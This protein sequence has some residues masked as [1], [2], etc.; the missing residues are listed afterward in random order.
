MT[1]F[2]IQEGIYSNQVLSSAQYHGDK[3]SISR[4][5]LMEFDKSPHRFRALFLDENAPIKPRTPAMIFGEA[6]HTYLLEPELF[7]KQFAITP[8]PVL[9]KDVG[10]EAYEAYKEELWQLKSTDKQLLTLDEIDA[11]NAM[12]EA[13]DRNPHA[14]DLIQ[15]A[16]YEQSFFWQHNV[17]GLMV[18]SRPDILHH[19]MYVDIKTIADA[20]PRSFQNSMV[21][22]GY[23]IQG[24]MLR[25]AIRYFEGRD[26]SN[27]INICVEKT[28]PFSI[29]IYIIDEAA[30]DFG[31]Q[32][33]QQNLLDLKH[34]IVQNAWNDY[35]PQTISLPRWALN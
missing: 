21:S 8:K 1:K 13:I 7:E 31:E 19:N 9:L 33:Y 30:L 18:K 35:E 26:M 28:Y 25:D 14:R 24:A 17:S 2:C 11:L 12:R 3:N 4:S 27:V 29:G 6:F 20:S 16:V 23:H 10:R 15:G 5:M 32:K 34:A 22:G